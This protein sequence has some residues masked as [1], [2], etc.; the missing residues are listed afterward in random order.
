MLIPGGFDLQR[1]DRG[2]RLW[3]DDGEMRAMGESRGRI[4]WKRDNV[5]KACLQEQWKNS[6]KTKGPRL[7]AGVPNLED[8]GK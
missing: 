8:D 4:I 6:S 2:R 7:W 3:E 5:S 1:G